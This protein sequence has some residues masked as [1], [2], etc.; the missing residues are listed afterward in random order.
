MYKV[1]YYSFNSVRSQTFDTL[2]EA[3]D[4]WGRL[5]FEAFRELYKL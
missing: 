1:V 4:F 2:G 5:P 3:F